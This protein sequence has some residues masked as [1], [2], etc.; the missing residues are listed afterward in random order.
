MFHFTDVHAHHC[1]GRLVFDAELLRAGDEQFGDA[2][3]GRWQKICMRT[4]GAVFTLI[5]N[6]MR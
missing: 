3:N 1:A 6:H 2:A 5:D 4:T